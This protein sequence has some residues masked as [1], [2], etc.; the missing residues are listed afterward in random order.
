MVVMLSAV[1]Q[2]YPRWSKWFNFIL[3]QGGD[4][5]FDNDEEFTDRKNYGYD[6]SWVATHEI[7]HSLGLE[8][9]YHRNAVMYPWYDSKNTG[10][11]FDLTYDDKIGIQTLYGKFICYNNQLSTMR[12]RKI[13]A[14][15]EET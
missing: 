3:A 15:C 14:I 8:H 4:V 2:I 7:G 12:T 5:H 11:K 9:S 10:K 6:L 1:L 13:E